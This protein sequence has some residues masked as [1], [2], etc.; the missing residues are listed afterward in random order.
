MKRDLLHCDCFESEFEGLPCKHELCIYI[1]ECKP[2]KCLRIIKR[3]E[4]SYFNPELISHEEDGNSDEDSIIF[5]DEAREFEN[6]E[7]DEVN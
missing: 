4:L 2:F 3:W 6:Q 5:E 7:N 1:K